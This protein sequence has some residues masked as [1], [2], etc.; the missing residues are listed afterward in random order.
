M[1]PG[2]S[3][4]AARRT[5]AGVLVEVEAGAFANPALAEALGHS[6]LE[7]RDR[8]FVTELVYGTLRMRRACDALVEGFLGGRMDRIDAW[9]RSCLRLGAYQLAFLGTAPHAALAAT[10]GA[11]PRRARPLV[12]AVLRKVAA[13]LPPSFPD[14]AVALSYPD[15][16]VDRLVADL[17][18]PAAIGALQAM[19]A[20]G[21][22]PVREDGYVQD[23]A[24]Q[25]VAALVSARPGDLVVDLCAAPGGKAT[26][27]AA[28]GLRVVAVDRDEG[29]ARL[30]GAVARRLGRRG[31]P[32]AVADGRR[33]P[34]RARTARAVLVDAPCSGLGAL[35]RRPDARWRVRPE[36][37]ERLAALQREL[38]TAGARLLAPGGLLV[39]SVCTLTRAETVEV[40]RFLCDHAPWLVAEAVPPPFEPL[41]RGGLLLPQV[42][43]TDGMFALV[44]R[45]E[46]GLAHRR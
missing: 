43:G 19:N 41:G 3:G 39:Y 10:V 21:G 12:N 46:P 1:T 42:E 30:V 13:N 18:E 36:D 2:R 17:G 38:V 33:P 14:R 28:R 44:L 40:D 5:A 35:R 22:A 37:V 6:R 32:V 25:L 34:L 26:A 11:A 20:R 9:T 23:R 31:L 29:R 45:F 24:S 16:I 15:W 7:P 4:V 8:A 27:L